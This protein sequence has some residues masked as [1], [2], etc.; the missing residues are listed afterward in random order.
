MKNK[1]NTKK[2]TASTYKNFA[3]FATKGKILFNN[4]QIYM[5]VLLTP[6]EA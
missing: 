4:N 3:E 1:M 2:K 6:I 5:I